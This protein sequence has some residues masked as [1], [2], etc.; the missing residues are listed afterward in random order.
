MAPEA[1]AN[2]PLLAGVEIG[3]TK[4][5]VALGTGDGKLTHVAK[6]A[7]VPSEGAPGVLRKI[8]ETLSLIRAE[9]G[10]LAVKIDA[11]GVGFGGPVEDDTGRVVTSHQVAGWDGFDLAQWSRQLLGCDRVR[12]ANDSDTAALAEAILAQAE[13]IRPSCTSTVAAASVAG[14]W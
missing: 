14:W 4:L 12:I 2:E 1:T 13:I 5:Q 10:Q 7:S 6:V 3:G 9:A 8:V 11:L